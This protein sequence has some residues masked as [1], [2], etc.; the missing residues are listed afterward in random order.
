MK[1][2]LGEVKRKKTANLVWGEKLP[3]RKANEEDTRK[4][5]KEVS[6]QGCNG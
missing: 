1:G 6:F 3:A 5:R 2:K 4:E